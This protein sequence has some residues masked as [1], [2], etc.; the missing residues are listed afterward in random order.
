MSLPLAPVKTPRTGRK[1]SFR[2]K[3]IAAAAEPE[4]QRLRKAIYAGK[5]DAVEELLP[6]RG[7]FDVYESR[8]LD[9]MS[10]F[11]MLK[12][13]IR[14]APAIFCL[15]DGRTLSVDQVRELIMAAG[16]GGVLK[17]P[18]SVMR[19]LANEAPVLFRRIQT[20]AMRAEEKLAEE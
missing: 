17:F 7:R 1:N 2:E 13:W 9:N 19:K 4:I 20:R 15:N 8:L 3:L 14:K 11:D 12:V 5:A 16:R 6:R 10:D 18:S